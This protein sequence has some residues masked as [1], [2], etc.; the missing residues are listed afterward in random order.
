VVVAACSLVDYRRFR[1]ACSLHHQLCKL[2]PHY[3]A[4]HPRRQPF[5]PLGTENLETDS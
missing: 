4:Q 2:V 5:S 1:D 3:T